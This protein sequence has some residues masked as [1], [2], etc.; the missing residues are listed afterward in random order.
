MTEQKIIVVT[1]VAGGGKTSYAMSL[2]EE[3]LRDGM[4]WHEIGYS[5]FSRAACREAAERAARITGVDVD[6][7]QNEGFFRTIHSAALRLLGVD[8]KLI[9]DHESKSGREFLTE[10]LGAQR[11]GEPGTLAAKVDDALNLWDKM[12]AQLIPAESVENPC[13]SR[14]SQG[15]TPCDERSYECHKGGLVTV[16]DGHFARPSRSQVL[17]QSD[18]TLCRDALTLYRENKNTSSDITK[19]NFHSEKINFV[20]ENKFVNVKTENDRRPSQNDV[21]P[22]RGKELARDGHLTETVTTVTL[23]V[24]SAYERAKKLNGRIDFTDIL[25]KYTGVGVNPDLSFYQTYQEGVTVSEIKLWIIDEYQDCSVLL[26]RV[27]VRL[28]EHAQELVLLG[29]GYQAVYGFSGSERAVFAFR[30]K[31]A[32]K[33]GNRVLLNRSWRNGQNIID[34]GEEVLREDREYEERMPFGEGD[35]G[36]VGM[37]SIRTLLSECASMADTDTMILS[38]TWFGLGRVQKVLDELCI[39]WACCQEKTKSRWEA[40]IKIAYTLVMRMLKAG[41][42]I[43]E[44]DWRRVTEEL[45]AKWEAK[46]L[47]VHGTKAKWKKAEC[48][49]EPK[50]NLD[51]LEEWGATPYFADF[52]RTEKWRK[53]NVLLLDTAIE[54]YGIDVVRKPGI[55]LGTVHSVKGMEAEN[56]FCLAASS[57]RVNNGADFFEELSLKYVAITRASRHY[58]VVVDEVDAAR[59]KP[60]FLA[61]PKGYWHIDQQMP[62][63]N[64]RANVRNSR[65]DEVF[66]LGEDSGTMDVGGEVS[67]RDPWD[68]GDAGH[69]DVRDGVLPGDRVQVPERSD[70]GN[71]DLPEKQDLDEWWS[72]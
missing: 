36:T 42:Q 67:G 1:G 20:N 11:G 9:I 14:L 37:I 66:E 46:K 7:L 43:S 44:H 5:S 51:E 24:I 60:M 38:R 4:K 72:L 17:T 26:D 8:P 35:E 39:P 23:D 69:P 30:E 58:R 62:E 6:K 45:P 40:P 28:A 29:D 21:S 70:H 71:A 53:D 68:Q 22:Y 50:R 52:V 49:M 3:K 19:K 33:E 27:A 31:Q 10:C 59:G 41:E 13:D 63:L 65:A 64:R 12:R 57:E 54:K 32:K 2:I 61:C 48:S 56:V 15:L 18:V 47:F 16:G 55:R 34:W 25:L